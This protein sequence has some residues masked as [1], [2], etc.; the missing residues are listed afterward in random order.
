MTRWV[1]R[2]L[3]E[4]S[5]LVVGLFVGIVTF[6]VT[7][8]GLA[9]SIGLLPA[10]LLGV[11]VLAVPVLR[12]ARPGDHGARPGR[13][14]A[15]RR[16]AGPAAAGRARGRL[17]APAAGALAVS[18]EFWKEAG[19]GLLLLPVGIGLGERWPLSFW[20]VA[21]A[22]LLFP[23]YAGSLPG[24]DAVT[25]LHWAQRPGGRGRVRRSVSSSCCW[26]AS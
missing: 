2:P 1:V 14:A 17:A 19:Y 23:L 8:T 3:L 21:V 26:P 11:P 4:L 10:F 5:Y 7:V 13:D 9:L 25:W 24:D 22:G 15:R 6:T 16:P 12:R 18:P 20:A